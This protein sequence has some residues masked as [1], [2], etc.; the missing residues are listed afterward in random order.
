MLI[1]T[2]IPAIAALGFGLV[3]SQGICDEDEISINSPGD[4][5][6]LSSCSTIAG[7]VTIGSL[8]GGP[9]R[10][11]GPETIRG[12]LICNDN[13][14]VTSISSS[15]LETIRGSFTLRNV[16]ALTTISLAELGS[17]QELD[18]Q[19]LT[20]LE[21][22]SFGRSGLGQADLIRISDTFLSTLNAISVTSTRRMEIDNNRRLV[23]WE[24]GLETLS[25]QLVLT[26]N[27]FG[28]EVGFP[29]LRWIANM[30]ISN[31]SSITVPSLEAVNGS[32]RFDSNFFSEFSAPNMTQTVDGDISF[33]DNGGLTNISFPVLQQVAGGFTIANNTR[34][35]AIDNFPELRTVGGAVLLRGN[36]TEVSLPSLN[37]VKGAFDVASTNDID[38]SCTEFERMAPSS[39]GGNGNIQGEFSCNSNSENANDVN[40]DGSSSG[41]NDGDN[42]GASLTVGLPVVLAMAGVVAQALM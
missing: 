6:Q 42:A 37:D 31:V 25:D 34:L 5:A 8:A 21:S 17:V 39:Q 32:M 24:S 27:G 9:I 19:T 4:A 28:L 11:D 26:A 18:W 10:I 41:G 30:T 13:G 15:S 36:F 3:S 29:S 14:I 12:D 23:E 7:T 33:T 16:T 38:D 40:T 1:K 22:V 20:R 35:Q 2:I